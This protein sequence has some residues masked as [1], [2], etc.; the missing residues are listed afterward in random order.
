MNQV[1][2]WNIRQLREHRAW[3]Q[4]DLA[5][6]AVLTTRTIQRVEAG[7]GAQLETLRSIASALEVDVSM[8]RIDTLAVLA[9]HLGVSREQLTPELIAQRQQEAEAKYTKVR[10]TKVATSADLRSV[11]EATSYYFDCTLKDD[12]VQDVAAAFQQDLHDLMDIGRSLDAVN[13]REIEV[14]V[15]ENVKKLD[16][17]GAV[18]TVG[19][20]RHYMKPA[21]QEAM[22]WVSIY[23]IVSA[24]DDVKEVVLIEKNQPVSFL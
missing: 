9:K 21:N 10:M 2:A 15:F 1:I 12:A 4:E 7:E 8:L 3:T 5:I 17:L 6:A 24:K 13:R 20:Q 19:L 14:S 18:V 11:S 22:P 23:V 16:K